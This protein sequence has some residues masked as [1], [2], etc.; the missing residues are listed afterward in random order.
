MSVLHYFNLFV[1]TPIVAFVT[2]SN[3]HLQL[4]SKC[5]TVSQWI[6]LF[7]MKT[8]MFVILY[9][10]MFHYLHRLF[11]T[12]WLFKNI[13]SI[14]HRMELHGNG[15]HCHP[16]EHA[17]VNIFPFCLSGYLVSYDYQMMIIWSL[18]ALIN[19]AY[20]HTSAETNHK[21]HHKYHNVNYGIGFAI[22][23]RIHSTYLKNRN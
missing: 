1:I 6:S 16:L 14:H 15:F 12:K 8:L 9:D 20:T 4:Y 3:F 22:F 5:V 10:F 19:N 13:H 7:L 17:I 11:H 2:F 21:L 23:D 18:V